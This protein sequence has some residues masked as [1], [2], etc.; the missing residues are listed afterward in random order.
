MK[1][2]IAASL[3]ATAAVAAEWYEY[4]Y[5]VEN[6]GPMDIGGIAFMNVGY[7]ISLEY[8][9]TYKAGE[10]PYYDLDA[11]GSTIYSDLTDEHHYE[12]YGFTVD[13]YANAYFDIGL[14]SYGSDVWIW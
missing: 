5:T 4:D 9:T 3:L 2:L 12:E 13:G 1:R 14:G 11:D 10:G 6:S 7:D 8:Y